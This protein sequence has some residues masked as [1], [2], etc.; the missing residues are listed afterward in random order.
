MARE[1]RSSSMDLTQ[2]KEVFFKCRGKKLSVT[3]VTE[4]ESF[5]RI[6][7]DQLVRKHIKKG[8]TK[9]TMSCLEDRLKLSKV[10]PISPYSLRKSVEY[11]DI[12]NFLVFTSKPGVFMLCIHDSETNKKTYESFCCDDPS[13]LDKLT[14][15]ISSAKHDPTHRLHRNHNTS[16]STMDMNTDYSAAEIFES[17][18]NLNSGSVTYQSGFL[19]DSASPMTDVNVQNDIF[20]AS[21]ASLSPSHTYNNLTSASISEPLNGF[22]TNGYAQREPNSSGSTRRMVQSTYNSP[23]GMIS[24]S[25]N[26]NFH[27]LIGYQSKNQQKGK[28]FENDDDLTPINSRNPSLRNL[29]RI[30]N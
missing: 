15:L 8:H 5:S 12:I 11:K 17:A 26:N 25:N 18:T 9:I 13:D 21:S 10:S 30:D 16:R 6:L 20:H 19:R 29:L 3:E 23:G 24:P 2:E 4:D 14:R 27:P 7:A 1:R 28:T 22:K